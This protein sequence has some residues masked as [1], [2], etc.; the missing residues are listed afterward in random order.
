MYQCMCIHVDTNTYILKVN[1]HHYVFILS[2]HVLLCNIM[3]CC[4]VLCSICYMIHTQIHRIVVYIYVH[5]GIVCFFRLVN[6]YNPYY[7]YF[8]NRNNGNTSSMGNIESKGNMEVLE[9]WG[10]MATLELWETLKMKGNMKYL[11]Y[12]KLSEMG[13]ALNTEKVDHGGRSE[14]LF[15]YF[16]TY[17]YIWI[18]VYI[19]IYINIYIIYIYIYKYIYIYIY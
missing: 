15:I 7:L 2:Y 18:Y 19:Y 9:I 16:Y 1:I 10:M 11:K 3:L 8:P 12:E 13:D 4:I 17:M 14:L 6:V 5:I